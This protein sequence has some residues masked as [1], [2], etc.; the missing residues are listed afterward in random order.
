QRAAFLLHHE[1]DCS[2][3]EMA[4]ALQIALEAAKSRL[5]YAM[6]KLRG[7]MGAY[8]EDWPLAGGRT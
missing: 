3:Q 4:A 6:T 5:R 7:C 1:D 8:L 2:L